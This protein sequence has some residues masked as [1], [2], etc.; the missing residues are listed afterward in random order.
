[1]KSKK[2][3]RLL[4]LILSMVLMLSASISAMAEGDAQNEASGTETTEN[5][6][7]AQSLEEE[8]VPE[9]EVPGEENGIAVQSLEGSE[10]PVQ[11]TEESVEEVPSETTV[12]AEE[13]VTENPAE[14][15]S[16]EATQ[17]SE[18]IV[19]EAADLYQEF[20][21][22]NGNVITSIRAYVP[23]GAFQAR[24]D[25]ITM[26]VNLLDADSD[27]YIKGMIEEK[28]PE[29]SYLGGYILY[30]VN[31]MVD[32]AITE[33][34]KAITLTI[35]G[36]G[37]GVTDLAKTKAFRY[38]AADPN[39]AGDK[40]E[41]IEMGQ[42]QDV[43]TYLAE[44]GIAEDQI[45]AYEYSELNVQNEV[46]QQI[47]FNTWKSTIYGCYTEAYSAEH[48]FTQNVNDMTVNVTVPEGALPTAVENVN[49]R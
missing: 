6:A 4:A 9:T 23:E 29:N 27:A 32:G 10:E 2:K 18:A 31:F 30:E 5:Q 15:S 43:L 16:Q 45:S 36:S 33:P 25:Q 47:G 12:P 34:A 20:K 13:E 1:M 40:D 39:V 26:Q 41:L 49:L 38:D 19:S 37:L 24:A 8:T 14:G 42:K 44:N 7:A 21:D 35:E 22:E 46:A 3:Q 17:E 48:T 11:E 28:L